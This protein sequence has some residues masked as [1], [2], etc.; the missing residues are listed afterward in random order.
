[1][2]P[3]PTSPALSAIGSPSLAPSDATAQQAA[4][5]AKRV[6]APIIHELAFKDQSYDELR[7]KYPGSETDFKNALDKVADIDQ[8]T[9]TYVLRNKYWKD[10]DVWA[11]DYASDD[12]RQEAIAR[13]IRKFDKMRLSLSDPEWDMLLRKEERGR[14]RVVSQLQVNIARGPAAPKI[15]VQ[16]PEDSS[17]DSGNGG[18]NDSGSG[19]NRTDEDGV[20]SD[21]NRSPS[22]PT[23]TKKTMSA[24]EAQEKRILS[25]KKKPTAAPSSIK[26]SPAKAGA[27]MSNDKRG[28]FKSEEF[29]HDSDTTDSES[30]SVPLS[31]SVQS[32]LA[33]SNAKA[34]SFGSPKVYA[35]RAGSPAVS[36]TKERKEDRSTPTPV[37][38]RKAKPSPL[39]EVTKP[40]VAPKPQPTK[41]RA[42][43]SSDD[44]SSSSGG[45]SSGTP[46]MK[47]IK[48]L[49]TAPKTSSVKDVR[50]KTTQ[51][52]KPTPPARASNV[53][54]NGSSDSTSSSTNGGGNGL[55]ISHGA[56]KT[57]SAN[58]T[59]SNT[60][61]VK[62][63]P[64]A[65]SPPTN[66][67]ELDLS[68]EES[69][70]PIGNSSTSRKRKMVDERRNNMSGDASSNGNKTKKRRTLPEDLVVKALQ[71]K[72]FYEKYAALYKDISSRTNPPKDRV[73]E[74]LK[75]HNRLQEM[76][77]SIHSEAM[78][79][80]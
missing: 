2:S 49:K 76:K 17:A 77:S 10:L 23:N 72:E 24:R 5:K 74:L 31:A 27:K 41:K 29:V 1:M 64:L 8:S 75:M 58:K 62:S 44:D 36:A 68:S 30:E 54:P 13:A 35:A 52:S 66:A 40:A 47:R 70:P 25:T 51:P 53:S 16:K 4:E 33:A 50:E 11:H 73:A 32:K 18:G 59:K 26:A 7:R 65:S 80:A 60:S 43:D 37:A 55:G 63:S 67:S 12:D 56:T 42:R 69:V 6:R 9:R 34:T 3:L 28:K 61:P 21:R 20:E 71:F 46:L 79:R 57:T 48:P 19:S 14:G 38:A 15:R 45:S 22:R 78:L 39:K